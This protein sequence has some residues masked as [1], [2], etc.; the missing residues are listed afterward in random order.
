MKNGMLAVLMA[1][2]FCIATV[3]A[4]EYQIP[5]GLPALPDAR[6]IISDKI[7]SPSGDREESIFRFATTATPQEVDTFYRSALEA[8]GFLVSAKSDK[9]DSIFTSGKRDRDRI[10]VSAKRDSEEVQPGEVEV[11]IVG[12]YDK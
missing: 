2:V 5:F 9:G 4:T 6:L 7:D 3:S 12:K 1:A 8:A 10:T 11:L